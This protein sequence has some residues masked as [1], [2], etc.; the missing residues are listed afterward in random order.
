M[1]SV[2]D[3]YLACAL[4]KIMFMMESMKVDEEY[5]RFDHISQTKTVLKKV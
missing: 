1:T 2:I 4:P 5:F 3:G